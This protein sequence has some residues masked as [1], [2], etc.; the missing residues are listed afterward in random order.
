MNPL[1]AQ[2]LSESRDLLEQIGASLLALEKSP[3]DAAQVDELFRAV[4]TLKG[5]SGL[6]PEYMAFTRLVHAGEDV[7]VDV[8][9]GAR[10]FS[11]DI[12]DRLLDAMDLIAV[13]LDSI[14]AEGDISPATR[15]CAE[16]QASALRAL[17]AGDQP[18]VRIVLPV[19]RAASSLPAWAVELGPHTSGS[20]FRYVPDA[21]CFFSG[22]D[23]LLLAL[24]APA[25][26][27]LREVSGEP[28]P[29]LDQFDAYVCRLVFV[30]ISEVEVDTLAEHFRCVSEQVECVSLLA[31]VADPGDV[32]R[33]PSEAESPPL[34]AGPVS[35][36][37]Q[38]AIE[39]LLAAQRRVLDA[40]GAVEGWAG[41]VRSVGAVLDSIDRYR[42]AAN[43][44]LIADAV[45]ATLEQ[46]NGAPLRV[47]LD[48]WSG[49]PAP[50]PRTMALA[51]PP[52]DDAVR[53]V[54]V[55]AD[56]LA[57]AANE[58]VRT[59]EVSGERGPR[60]L[61]VAQEKVDRLMDLIGEMVVAKNALPYLAARAEASQGGREL[62]REIKNQHAVINR[63][64]EEMQDAIMQ[65]RML[66]VATVFQRF[67]RL[68][69]DI[70]RKLGKQVK[71]AIEGEDTE[72]DKNIVESLSDPL[73]H[74]VRNSL[75][76]GLETPEE[77]R[78]AGK[79]EAGVLRIR[80]FQEAD[81]VAIEI[82]DDGRGIDPDRIRAKA[83]EKGLID[84]ERAQSMSDDDVVQLVFAP[85]FST[86]EA[87]SDL[88]GR[89]VG[90]DVVRSAIE[91][92]H[93]S[94]QL[95]SEKGRGTRIRIALPLSMAVTSVMIIRSAGQM[96]GVQMDAVVETVRVPRTAI[97]RIKQMRTAVLR[98]RIVPLY[99]LNDLLGVPAEPLANDEGEVAVL[100]VR[101]L[102][103]YVG[104]IVDDFDATL[105]L[106]LKPM[107]GILSGLAGYA[108]TAL[109]GDGSVLMVLNLKELL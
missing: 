2:F 33:P 5:N 98:G 20:A 35:E 102:G 29:P 105:D 41:R 42:G 73:I 7:L 55:G 1:L 3:D 106:I 79:D 101:L 77:R 100:V 58:S 67:P 71:L 30:G 70:S 78:A 51:R 50:T 89:G 90:M 27:E 74:I 12:A 18:P 34:D 59:E 31:G 76:H 14:E 97:H 10:G 43:T 94:V 63:I 53:A 68:V 13:M 8:R 91:R 84:V 25:L 15:E 40:E 45:E 60:V 46:G 47:L 81:R 87:V 69:R 28:W 26:V 88:S 57:G 64:A 54:A 66:P 9:E 22:E 92:A 108:G 16:A 23:P 96:Y 56:P 109:L 61:K 62:A 85:G 39:R 95:A 82:E 32:A 17:R 107:D 11:S 75:D 44:R 36:E 38:A 72:A 52:A 48:A 19:A 86:A 104:V 93:G 6:F 103:Q 80:A 21:Q 83:L 37:E 49:A 99:A 24:S 4:H 65:V